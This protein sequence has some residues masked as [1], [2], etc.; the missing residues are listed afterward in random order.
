M[1]S[2]GFSGGDGSFPTFN[3]V[4]GS[5]DYIPSS[6]ERGDSTITFM[7]STIPNN[8]CLARDTII[9][10]TVHQV[11]KAFAGEDQT[12]CRDV[13][14]ITVSGN[15]TDAISQAW[16]TL[17]GGS[18]VPSTTLLS[19][20]SSVPNDTIGGQ[21]ILT[22]TAQGTGPCPSHSD[23]MIVFFTAPPTLD[24]TTPNAQICRDDL[25]LQLNTTLTVAGGVSWTTDG[26]GN[27]A[28]NEFDADPLYTL[29]VSDTINDSLNFYV[30]NRVEW[31][32]FTKV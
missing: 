8:N 2:I 25:S 26:A 6:S 20:Y 11:A 19:T 18:F 3:Q 27:F 16:S 1:E 4:A 23:D 5:A 22:L 31:D 15:E 13:S 28:A 12:Q 7:A 9:T 29:D 14:I 21:I 24:A 17:G 10:V 30:Q 32:L